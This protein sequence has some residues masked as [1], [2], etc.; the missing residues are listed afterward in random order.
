MAHYERLTPKSIEALMLLV[1]PQFKVTGRLLDDVFKDEGFTTP[2][3]FIADDW[4]FKFQIQR[5]Q[6]SG[7]EE[8]GD[9]TYCQLCPRCF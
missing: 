2:I 1:T 5:G 6:A 3:V 7:I 9:E 4:I 8:I